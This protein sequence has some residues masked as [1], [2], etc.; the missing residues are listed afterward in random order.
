VGYSTSFTGELKFKKEA[1]SKQLA[2][3]KK[4]LDQDRRQ[5][6]FEDDSVYETDNEYWYHIDLEFN[7]DFSGVRWNEAEKTYCLEHIVNFLTKQMRKK[8]KD[9]E[10]VGEMSA[11]GEEYDDRWT[12]KMVDGVAK[13]IPIVIKGMEVTCPHCEETLKAV[14][15]PECEETFVINE[16]EQ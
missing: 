10:F 7:D 2:E 11:Q 13:K 15:C 6:G 9:F 8:W 14:M 12:L 16:E 3:L 5:I 4:F 1:T